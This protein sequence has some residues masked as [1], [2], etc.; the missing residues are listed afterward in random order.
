[1]SADIKTQVENSPMPENSVTL[2]LI[3]HLRINF[4]ELAL[5]RG[6]SYMELP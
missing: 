1:M 4:H 6:S 2:D 5:I 3:R